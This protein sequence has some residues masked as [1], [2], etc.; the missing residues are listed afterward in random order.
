MAYKV[1]TDGAG[2]RLVRIVGMGDYMPAQMY[3]ELESKNAE[4]RTKVEFMARAI[5][6]AYDFIPAGALGIKSDLKQAVNYP[7]QTTTCY[8]CEKPAVVLNKNSRCIICVTENFEKTEAEFLQA[9]SFEHPDQLMAERDLALKAQAI[10]EFANKACGQC[11]TPY[12][13]RLSG[14]ALRYVK[15]LYA[16]A[17]KKLQPP[18]EFSLSNPEL[19]LIRQWFESVQDTNT[20]FLQVDDYVLA[21]KI[22]ERLGLRVPNSIKNGINK[23]D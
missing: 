22:Y 16:K 11:R 5:N 9:L 12:E 3:S 13:N 1:L 20:E 17:A 21:P 15:E 4:L 2:S 10:T 14:D 19:H 7:H 6:N 8:Q 23:N 18:V